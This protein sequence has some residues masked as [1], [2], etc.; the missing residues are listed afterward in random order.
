MG[1]LTQVYINSSQFALAT[2][3]FTD[4]ALTTLA[5]DGFYSM[6]GI[7]RE[8]V[9]GVLGKSFVC[10]ACNPL[11]N[12][13][14]IIYILAQQGEYDYTAYVG[15]G[16]GAIRIHVNTLGGAM[17]F[18]AEYNSVIHND[19]YT[20]NLGK[21]ETT[22]AGGVTYIGD[23][24]T[25]NTGGASVSNYNFAG[26]DWVDEGTSVTI[27]PF[28][29]SNLTNAT[30]HGG[31][32]ITI[33]KISTTVNELNLKIRVPFTNSSAT[34]RIECVNLL[35]AFNSSQAPE[36]NSSDGCDAAA[37]GLFYCSAING[38]VATGGLTMEFVAVGD[39]VY[40][41]GFGLTAANDGW[42]GI[43]QGAMQVTDGV[44]TSISDCAI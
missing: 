27:N 18:S 29:G 26:G 22:S 8:Q 25:F 41:D 33:P 9:S 17:G 24:S 38:S 36:T 40:N 15:D 42:Y 16:I 6:Q 20:R 32:V 3:V 5:A 39:L 21:L 10:E 37:T 30:Y 14:E 23:S 43:D 19:I 13:D 12:E 2:A 7:V 34:F 4:Q 1:Q 44:I 31:G 28:A 35:P 11:C